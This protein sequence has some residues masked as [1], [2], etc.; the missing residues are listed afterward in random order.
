MKQ[1][2]I[3]FLTIMS[4]DTIASSFIYPFNCSMYHRYDNFYLGAAKVMNPEI[5]LPG[6]EFKDEFCWAMGEEHANEMLQ[7]AEYDRRLNDCLKAFDHGHKEGL[8]GAQRDVEYPSYCYNI[9]LHSGFA[10]LGNFA[11]EGREDMVGRSCLK[12]FDRGLKD[13]EA[14]RPQSPGFDNKLSVCYLNGY[15]IGNR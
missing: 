11:R 6:V 9:G 5:E 10:A 4:F 12:S 13:G 1:S 3:L 8:N 7:N 2:L 14:N 15:R